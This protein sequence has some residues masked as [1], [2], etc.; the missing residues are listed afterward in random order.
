M[1]ADYTGSI[2]NFSPKSIGD[3]DLESLNEEEI[4]WI[5]EFAGKKSTDITLKPHT[6]DKVI[7]ISEFT[8]FGP[9]I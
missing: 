4:N 7:D 9:Y 1:G 8:K 6:N 5:H 2:K 3:N